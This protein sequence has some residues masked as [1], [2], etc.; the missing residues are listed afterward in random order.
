MAQLDVAAL[1]T[2]LW[3]F[4]E[5]GKVQPAALKS[6]KSKIGR[7]KLSAAEL[8]KLAELRND[9]PQYDSYLGGLTAST[10][11]AQAPPAAPVPQAFANGGI[12]TSPRPAQSP[13]QPKKLTDDDFPPLG[14]GRR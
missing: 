12:Q 10:G 5:K 9:F 11:T 14:G 7:N 3:L 6:M 2:I 1:S 4:S 8:V 13:A